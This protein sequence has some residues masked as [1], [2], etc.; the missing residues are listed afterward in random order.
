MRAELEGIDQGGDEAL[1]MNGTN[2]FTVHAES[3]GDGCYGSY[4]MGSD[5]I[6]LLAHAIGNVACASA[7]L[8]C[9]E[10]EELGADGVAFGEDVEV[11]D[12]EVMEDCFGGYRGP[13]HAFCELRI[14][15]VDSSRAA[16]GL[17]TYL[18]SLCS[19]PTMPD[20]RT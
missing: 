4:G 11:G 3:A 13:Y 5:G 9:G 1:D 8:E 6:A 16:S 19:E 2:A 12:G 15:K 14:S 10:I 18:R 17:A 7:G 20:L